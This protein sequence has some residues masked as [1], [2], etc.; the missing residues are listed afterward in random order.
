MPDSTVT[1]CRTPAEGSEGVVNVPTWKCQAVR[2]AIVHAVEAA[3]AEGMLFS[4]LSA[5]VR[6]RLGSV[7]WHTT[8]VKLNMEVEGELLRVPG[9][10]P[11]R[12]VPG[13]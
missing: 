13:S 2:R 1:A 7:G 4:Q 9:A 3:G 12:L 5:A 10:S 11:Q 6:A 8:T